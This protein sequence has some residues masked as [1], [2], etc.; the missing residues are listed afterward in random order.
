MGGSIVGN[1]ARRP[2]QWRLVFGAA[3][4]SLAAVGRIEAGDAFA[5]KT[6]HSK[7]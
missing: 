6:G 1:L 3:L 7:P 4:L 5:A 2:G